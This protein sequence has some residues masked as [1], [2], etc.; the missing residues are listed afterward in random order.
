[1]TMRN[2]QPHDPL[3]SE[4]KPEIVNLAR[5]RARC[6]NRELRRYGFVYVCSQGHTI[7]VLASAFRGRTPVPGVGGIT[8]P[9]C[10]PP[11]S[12]E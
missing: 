10:H 7:R 2:G 6:Y 1:M 12:Q 5:P 3:A 4:P 11:Q 8:C 9:Q